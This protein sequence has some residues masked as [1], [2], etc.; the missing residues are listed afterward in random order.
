ML[1]ID[2]FLIKSFYLQLG[3]LHHILTNKLYI[4]KANKNW[5]I[6]FLLRIKL[7]SL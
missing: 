5:D 3:D 4:K 1:N 7:S 6:L 2:S